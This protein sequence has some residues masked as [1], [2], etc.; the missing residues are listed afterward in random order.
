[1]WH[2]ASFLVGAGL[3]AALASCAAPQAA[4][5]APAQRPA[6][7]HP[8]YT[9]VIVHGAWG[10]SWDW[11]DVDHRLRADGHDV[12]RPSLTGQGERVHL[13]SPDIDLTTHIN[14]VVNV[15]LFEKLH[16][17]I[18]VGHSYWGMV[19][20]G[21]ADKVPERIKAMVYVDAF[22]PEDGQ[23]LN[24]ARPAPAGGAA[25][26]PAGRGGAGGMAGRVVNGMVPP[27]G[28][29]SANPPHDVPQSAK[30][31]SEAISL[32]NP[33]GKVI[34]TVYLLLI[35]PGR[36]AQQDTFYPFYQRAQSRGWTTWS[37][38]SDHNAQRSHPAELVK[39][40]E[41]APTGAKA[42]RPTP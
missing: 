38:E 4:P 15:I 24:T 16:D 26:A 34:P 40:L 27:M 42:A 10:G 39:F 41:D 9:Y 25:S 36:T 5:S 30:T 33:A 35:D 8:V 21:V 18:L 14:D 37:F 11:K 22:L 31:F 28:T 7:D 12:Y 20:T 1:M 17:I 23:S 6:A 3:L 13:A 32:K 29:V 2:T 19:I